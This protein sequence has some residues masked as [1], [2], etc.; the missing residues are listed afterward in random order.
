MYKR[1][2]KLQRR[3]APATGSGADN[4]TV[5]TQAQGLSVLRAAT[6]GSFAINRGAQ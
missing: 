1:H 5:E 4:R 2:A 6:E 3:Q